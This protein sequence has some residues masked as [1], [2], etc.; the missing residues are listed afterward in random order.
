MK[1]WCIP[2]LITKEQRLLYYDA[3]D[4]AHTTLD[5]SIFIELIKSLLLDELS[6][7]LS[8]LE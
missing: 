3:L 2:V 4:K 8:I 5:Y 1:D 6:Y 7:G